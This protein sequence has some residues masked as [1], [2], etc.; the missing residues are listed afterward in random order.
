[1][2]DYLGELT[3]E[4]PVVMPDEQAQ[5]SMPDLVEADVPVDVAA[6]MAAQ[7]PP[8]DIA[9]AMAAGATPPPG[10]AE[11][12]E[13][14]S[15]NRVRQMAVQALMG[16]LPHTEANTAIQ[17]FIELFGQPALH[18][19][20]QMVTQMKSEQQGKAPV[21]E[22]MISGPGGGLGDQI[23]ANVDGADPVALSSGEFIVPADVVSGLGDGDSATG[24]DKL[25]QMMDQVRQQRTGSAQQAPPLRDQGLPTLG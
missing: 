21:T 4:G 24:A 11:G 3:G 5:I 23:V 6:A 17:K 9:A 10:M 18:Q 25:H 13:V 16:Q 7:A 22:G 14:E 1:M 15:Q 2:Q 20:M 8:V 19:L 12:G